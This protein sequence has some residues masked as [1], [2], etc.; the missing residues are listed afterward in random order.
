MRQCWNLP[1]E[2]E[3][4]NT[5]RDWVLH[6][7]SKLTEIQR[8]MVLMECGMSTTITH[9]KPAPPVEAFKHFLCSYVDSLLMIKQSPA[10]DV[11][12][13]K[14]V[15]SY[16]D[17]VQDKQKKEKTMGVQKIWER[18]VRGRLK[19]NNNRSFL[20]SIGEAG[21]GMMLHGADGEVIFTACRYLKNYSSALKAE[22]PAC[23]EGRTAIGPALVD[24]AD[25]YG[26]RLCYCSPDADGT[27]K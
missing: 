1:K 11:C 8:M 10:E 6:T 3:V 13:G 15:I 4:E 21:A 2:E 26:N 27:G 5:G 9:E 18:P 14:E 22:L 25:R 17:S 19:L 23:K 16:L 24:S 12:K 20:E 7:I